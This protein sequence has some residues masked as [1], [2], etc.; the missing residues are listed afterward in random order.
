MLC[1]NDKIHDSQTTLQIRPYHTTNTTV[2]CLLV[3]LTI[4]T[5]S[6]ERLALIMVLTLG[7]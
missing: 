3:C 2:H 5:T 7:I 4:Q 1:Q 6:T